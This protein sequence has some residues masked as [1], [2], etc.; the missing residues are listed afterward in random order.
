MNLLLKFEMT[1]HDK[2][3]YLL[4]VG[5]LSIVQ[6]GKIGNNHFIATSGCSGWQFKGAWRH[7]G[8]GCIPKPIDT[9]IDC[10]TTSTMALWLPNVKGVE[11]SFF[12]IAPFQVKL[13]GGVTRGD[14]GIHFDAN[15]PGSAGCIVIRNQPDWTRFLSQMKDFNRMGVKAIPLQVIYK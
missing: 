3:N 11:G 6:D 7:K 12:P 10:F 5:K 13:S 2:P 14:F 4:Q 9:G 8:K 15:V 1:L